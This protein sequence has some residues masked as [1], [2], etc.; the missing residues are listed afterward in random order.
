MR[1]EAES[2]EVWRY[3]RALHSEL[4]QMVIGMLVHQYR[5]LSRRHRPEERV[6]MRGARLR[7]AL[8]EAV[9]Q[10]DHARAPGFELGLLAHLEERCR[11]VV[12]PHWLVVADHGA[13]DHPADDAS[14]E[15]SRRLAITQ[16]RLH[17]P[18][19]LH[20]HLRWRHLSP[21]ALAL[22]T[23]LRQPPLNFRDGVRFEQILH[24]NDTRSESRAY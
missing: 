24:G 18:S 6:R 17:R 16:G 9:H 23:Q 10:G 14:D 5:P 20:E 11:R 1:R 2:R 12:P 4:P 13:L 7:A 21:L 15:H 8:G 19:A 3:T 22:G